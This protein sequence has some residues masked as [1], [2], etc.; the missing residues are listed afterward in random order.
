MPPA[1]SPHHNLGEIL[2]REGLISEE[3]FKQGMKEYELS[4][5]PLSRIFTD[6]GAITEGV[7]I[8][9]LQKRLDC[10]VISLRDVSPR[11]EAVI[12]VPRQVCQKHHLVPIKIDQRTLIVAM[13]DP[14]DVRAI[15]TVET[16]SSMSVRPM[17]AKAAEIQEAI[18][19][20][21][22]LEAPAESVR[23]ES[24]AFRILRRVTL[25]LVLVLPIGSFYYLL[26]YNN[27]FKK[28]WTME[29]QL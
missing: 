7:K 18:K 21:P 27:A 23:R 26:F 4:E 17:L 19:N 16:A 3:Q 29:L 9:V 25:P 12:L 28:Y 8:G 10:E 2:L 24:F 22:E 1:T 13:E 11:P 20:L 6:M 14:T 5:R 15:N